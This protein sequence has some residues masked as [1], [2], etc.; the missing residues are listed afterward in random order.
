MNVFETDLPEHANID[1]L[2]T[3]MAEILHTE[4]AVYLAKVAAFQTAYPE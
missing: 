4:T 3:S 1:D 2:I